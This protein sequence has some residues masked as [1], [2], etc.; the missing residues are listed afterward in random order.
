MLQLEKWEA[1]IQD[2]EEM[3]RETPEDETLVQGLKDA[4]LQLKKQR[5]EDASDM[6]VG[7]SHD[8]VSIS[9]NEHFRELVTSPGKLFLII[10]SNL[11]LQK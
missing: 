9:S 7:G 6:K 4:Q 3:I 10:T 11:G 2:Y 5:G 8:V 1:C